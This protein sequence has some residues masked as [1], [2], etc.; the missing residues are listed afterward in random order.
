MTDII[1]NDL[2]VSPESVIDVLHKEASDTE[3]IFV[4]RITKELD[5]NYAVSSMDSA[6]FELLLNYIQHKFL[7]G[8]TFKKRGK[9]GK[10][11]L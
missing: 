2:A 10:K 5:I 11:N 9:N 6:D 1:A 4:V 8:P 7:G 3:A